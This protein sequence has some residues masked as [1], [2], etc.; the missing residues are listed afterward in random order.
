[1]NLPELDG[2]SPEALAVL[3]PTEETDET[4]VAEARIGDL[5]KGMADEQRRN[6]RTLGALPD[7]VGL[8]ARSALSEIAALD[9]SVKVRGSGRVLKQVPA[10]DTPLSEIH[11][12]IFL[13]LGTL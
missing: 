4:Q 10:P 8:D 2:L 13:Q 12:V 5:L 6:Q 7:F 1:M 9:L 3:M 11:G